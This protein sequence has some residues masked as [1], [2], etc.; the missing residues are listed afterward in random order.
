[1]RMY[2]NIVTA[3]SVDSTREESELKAPTLKNSQDLFPSHLLS[4]RPP[5][6]VRYERGLGITPDTPSKERPGN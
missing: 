1:M 2:M 5:S 3:L 4:G 6:G